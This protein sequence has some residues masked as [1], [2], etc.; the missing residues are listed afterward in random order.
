VFVLQTH[1]DQGR[2]P[3][4]T[5]AECSKETVNYG[6]FCPESFFVLYRLRQ[7]FGEL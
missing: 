4:K 2:A 6:N 3:M 1:S 7:A 5:G